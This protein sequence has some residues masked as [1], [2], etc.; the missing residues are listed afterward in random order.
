MEAYFFTKY[1]VFTRPFVNQYIHSVLEMLRII[2]LLLVVL[3]LTYVLFGFFGKKYSLR[4]DNF[5]IA[6]I[7]VFLIN[8]VKYTLRQ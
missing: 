4:I 3:A 8:R 2:L 7:N 1:G 6:G 5:N